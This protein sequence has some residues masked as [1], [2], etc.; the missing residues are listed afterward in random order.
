ML[1]LRE[2]QLTFWDSFL[3]AEL[4]GL[5]E[6]LAKVDTLLDDTQILAPYVERF[7]TTMG[8]PTVP[9]ETYLRLMY[10]KF[11]YQL[12]YETLVEEVSDS[13]QWRR[14]CRIP[15]DKKVPHSTTLIKLT[16][17]FGNELIEELN[18]TLI[19]KAIEQKIIRGRKLRVD[20]T[21]VESDIH[22]PTDA[23]LLVDGVKVITRTV[24]KLKEVAD[25]IPAQFR[26]RT[27]SIKKQLF[28]ITKISRRRSGEAYQEVKQITGEIMATAAKVSREAWQ[29]VKAAKDTASSQVTTQADRLITSLKQALD[30]TEQIISQTAE[31]LNGN[32]QSSNRIVSIFDPEARPIRK[33]KLKASTEFGY[34]VLLQETEEQVVTGYK[35]LEGN[36]SDDTLLQGAVND[37][38]KTFRRNPRNVATDRGLGSQKNEIALQ[39][40]GIKRCSLPR[41]GKLSPSRKKYQSQ[42]WFKQLQRWRAGQE[43]TISTLKRC[44]A[45]RRSRFRG[46][47]G[48]KTWVGFSIFTYNLRRLALK[49]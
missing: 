7:H 20:T 46:S 25:S 34:K 39:A 13:I 19:E 5:R 14:F 8:R 43:A 33:G 41:R 32:Q 28:S 18:Q 1:I 4:Q 6:E 47:R 42:P 12:G 45:L 29:V 23:S 16:K 40:M 30:V 26:D 9:I 31:V 24:K 10:L 3:P 37:H 21:V 15:L 44:Y 22:Y 38:R 48:T 11:R 36:P 27:R 49:I 2:P 17:R 35:V